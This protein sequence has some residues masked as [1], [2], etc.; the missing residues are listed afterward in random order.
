MSKEKNESKKMKV[1]NILIILGCSLV[2]FGIMLLSNHAFAVNST[3]I[4]ETLAQLEPNLSQ[5]GDFHVFWIIFLMVCLAVFMA[6]MFRMRESKEIAFF[7]ISAVIIGTILTII[8]LSPLD[9][10]IKTDVTQIQ[11]S[12]NDT[13]VYDAKVTKDVFHT[14]IIP[15]DKEFR[16]MFSLIFTGV[17]LF[18]GLYT[19]FILTNF[20]FGK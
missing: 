16:L 13:I 4:N 17:T 10:D 8:L 2:V 9:F 5:S 3:A 14:V 11:V 1:L 7:S 15:N 20:K 19:I 12:A 6:L 18:N